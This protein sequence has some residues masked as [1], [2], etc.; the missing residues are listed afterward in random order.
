[1]LEEVVCSEQTL[2]AGSSRSVHPG[3]SI[4]EP[5]SAISKMVAF[6]CHDLRLPL[7]AI[8]ANA[9][10][11]IQSDINEEERIEFYQEIHSAIDRM[12]E[13]LSSL[14]DYS[15]EGDV[16]RPAIQ[17]IV[18]TVGR[19]IRITAVR[20]EFERIFIQHHHQGL[21]V[22]WFDSNRFECVIANL[23]LNA[24]EAVSPD[25]GQI[26]ITTIGNPTCLHVS[27]WDNGPGISPKIR[28]SI[29]QPFVRYGKAEGSGLGLAIAKKFVEDHGGDI[30]L[31][32]RSGPGTLFRISIP[33]TIPHGATPL[34]S[35]CPSHSTCIS[36]A[37]PCA[38]IR[39]R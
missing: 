5:I 24:C 13:L 7:T 32:E 33:F 25:S 21:A 38:E 6:I 19:V 26:V 18:D 31:D 2:S 35:V 28:D 10:F 9:E 37:T 23:L 17:S 1:M 39:S 4:P 11:L 34:V 8:L 36:E 15:K 3:S 12:N 29:F 16:V 22:G 14:S 27:V 20:R 30:Y